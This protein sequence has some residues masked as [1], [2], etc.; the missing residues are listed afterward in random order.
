MPQVTIRCPFGELDLGE[1]LGIDQ[2]GIVQKFR[3]A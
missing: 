3:N 2:K 1:Q